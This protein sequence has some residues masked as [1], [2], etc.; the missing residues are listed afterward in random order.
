MFEGFREDIE[1]IK[2]RDPAA[3]SSFDAVLNSTGMRAVWAYRRQNWLWRKGFKGLARYLSTRSRRRFAIEIHP[4]AT[5]GRRFM[6]DHGVGVVIGETTV[7]GDDCLIYQ[8]VTLGGTGKE[9]GK[10]HPTL[11]NDVVIGVGAAVLGNITVGDGAK[12]GGGAVVVKD[13]PPGCTA[14]GVPAHCVSKARQVS[15]IEQVQKRPCKELDL[16]DQ[17]IERIE[18]TTRKVLLPDPIEDSLALLER[19]ISEMESRCSSLRSC[20]DT[21]REEAEQR[22]EED[23]DAHADP[24]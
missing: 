4:C 19:R 6:I 13:V 15:E 1:M 14:V 11:G 24:R 22:K 12:V 3:T 21:T 9:V 8:G 20:I 18:D 2:R 17:A 23:S 10:R 16:L 5:I 7:I